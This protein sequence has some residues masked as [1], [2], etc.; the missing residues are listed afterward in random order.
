M[1]KIKDWKLDSFLRTGNGH[2]SDREPCQD[3]LDFVADNKRIIAVLSDGI[4]SAPRAEKA[5]KAATDTVL[6]ILSNPRGGAED[7][8]SCPPEEEA[9]R[10]VQMK[11]LITSE[12]RRRKAA[13]PE[14]DCT[15]VFVYISLV[16]QRAFVGYIGDSCVCALKSNG[17]SKV[18]TQDAEY[19]GA[20][21]SL[22]YPEAEYTMQLERMA[23][24]EISGFM[25][26]SDGVADELYTKGK[27]AVLFKAAEPYVNSVFEKNGHAE[28]ERRLE[29]LAPDDDTSIIII[30]RR[31]VCLKND[32]TW[33]CSC[34]CRNPLFR[35]NCDN[36]RTKFI[37]LYGNI[38]KDFDG[39]YDML[40]YL[41]EH[42]EE[43]IRILSTMPVSPVPPAHTPPP[44]AQNPSGRRQ[45]VQRKPFDGRNKERVPSQTT[46]QVPVAPPP[47]IQKTVRETPEQE[48]PMKTRK[49]GEENEIPQKYVHGSN[50]SSRNNRAHQNR[51]QSGHVYDGRERETGRWNDGEA[52]RDRRKKGTYQESAHQSGAS[53]LVAGVAAVLAL[54]ACA[55]GVFGF[56]Q[57][58]SVSEKMDEMN[59]RI[60]AAES[61]ISELEANDSF[62]ANDVS[63]YGTSQ[64]QV[65]LQETPAADTSS[66]SEAASA[67]ETAAS[68]VALYHEPG[69]TDAW[70]V[71]EDG[72]SI[73][74]ETDTVLYNGRQ[75]KKVTTSYGKE[76]WI[77]E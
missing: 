13:Y 21:D 9:P 19:N 4:S 68:T 28:T 54:G 56:F 49:K 31:P 48:K 2:V 51:S 58:T 64:N 53:S 18:F 12:F 24:D 27:G 20:T 73:V 36:C 34:G 70:S 8:L 76:G 1:V 7:F 44:N 74:S 55:L 66:Q 30:M 75:W 57:Q 60:I 63:G 67:S 11:R 52:S 14:A 3:S 16:Q 25:L 42:P 38:L 43:E 40:R 69:D 15:L 77:V 59:Q 46:Q 61:R 72:E 47:V 41:N 10:S 17:G 62:Y 50:T 23:L 45:T 37:R 6:T 26:C 5:S 29:Q 65:I 22:D 39:A 32:P 33:L 35:L 71:L